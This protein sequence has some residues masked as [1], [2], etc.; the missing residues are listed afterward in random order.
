MPVD[1]RKLQIVRE[2]ERLAYVM[3]ASIGIPGTRFRFGIDSLIG[4]VPG[5]GDFAGVGISLYI[6]LRARQLGVP[7]RTLFKMLG[8]IAADGL[9]G[10]V[11]VAGD[12]FDAAF[13]ANLR[14][15]KL[16]LESV[17]ELRAALEA[18]DASDPP[19]TAVDG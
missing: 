6:L 3:D 2:L 14:N 11:P 13:R 8:N 4:L 9:L 19:N 15:V 10:T 5:V 16:A 1:E 18:P 17:P 12:V 7:K